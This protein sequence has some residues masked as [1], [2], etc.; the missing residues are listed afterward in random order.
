MKDAEDLALITRKRHLPPSGFRAVVD[1]KEPRTSE[2]LCASQVGAT[3][4]LVVCNR[5]CSQ[6]VE[7]AGFGIF[8]HLSV[9]K[10]VVMLLKPI[11]KFRVIDWR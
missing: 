1:D 3:S 4:G 8:N 6:S 7:L 2:K 11:S 9:P 10:R 5:L